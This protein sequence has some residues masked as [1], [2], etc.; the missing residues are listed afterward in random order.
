[1]D[2]KNS[3]AYKY[4]NWC[5]E[6]DNNKVGI[7]VKKQCKKWINIVN[8]KY[9]D[10]YFDNKAYKK[11]YKLL[12]LMIHPDLHKPLNCCLDDYAE[13]FIYATLCTKY[14]DNSKLYITSLLEIARKNRKTFYAAIIFILEMLLEN[15]FDRYF[16]VAPDLKLSKELKLA[17]EK[18]IK[19]SPLISKHFKITRDYTKCKINDAEY[20]A[21]AYSKDNMDGKLA[22]LWLADEAGNL[23]T[24][25]VEAMKSSQIDLW[26]KQGVIIST[27]YPNDNNVFLDEIDYAKKILDGLIENKRYF[28]LLYEPNNNLIKEWE[29]NDLVIYQSNPVA[30]GNEMMFDTLKDSREMAIL[31]EN[32]R[33]NYL[34]KH[35]NIMYQGLGIEGFIDINKVKE[36][37]IEENSEF[38]KGKDVYLGFD[39]SATDDNTSIGMITEFNGEI[40]AKSWG[41]IPKDR[42]ALKSNKEK[43]DYKKMI[44]EGWCYSC[45]DEVI[46]YGFIEAFAMNIE[47]EYSVNILQIGYD[48]WNALSTAQKLEA[49]GYEMIEVKQHSSILHMPT[50]LL[51]ESILNQKFKYEKNRL[52]EINFQNARC[53]Y[54]TNENKYINKKRSAGK[55]DMVVA[56]VIALYLLQQEQLNGKDCTIQVI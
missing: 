51:Y 18:I 38:W 14:K 47:N 23:D 19:S 50:K 13:L 24:Y 40:Y 45:G 4:A 9:T 7:Y 48:R 39:L 37:K 2:I 33:E 49:E 36:C 42:V 52:L 32:K 5:I 31:Y 10:C 53:T 12:G 56:L 8:G 16:S 20:V 6:S 22:R 35:N 11:I 54:D 44:K 28:S 34:C 25:P 26:N 21:L 3:K 17:I 41:F 55:V 43:V 15:R 46:D 1:M 29:T 27:Q 30:V